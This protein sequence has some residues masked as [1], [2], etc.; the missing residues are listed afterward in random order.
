[1]RLDGLRSAF[2]GQLLDTLAGDREQTVSV[3]VLGRAPNGGL[4]VSAS[5]VELALALEPTYE[6]GSTIRVPQQLV[7][8]AQS[9]PRDVQAQALPARGETTSTITQTAKLLAEAIAATP[10]QAVRPTAPLATG[11]APAK[12]VAQ[13]LKNSVDVSGLFYESHVAEWAHGERPIAALAAEPQMQWARRADS[14][15]ATAPRTIVPVAGEAR[16]GA[17][18]LAVGTSATALAPE[19][20]HMIGQQAQVLDTGRVVWQGAVWPGQEARVTFEREP[21]V[22]DDRGPRD[23]DEQPRAAWRTTLAADLPQLGRV[24]AV[25]AFDGARVSVRLRAP[26]TGAVP[27]LAASQREFADALAAAGVAIDSITVT[28]DG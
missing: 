21:V 4:L 6:P 14:V 20:T 3:V 19:A 18:P 22:E 10:E 25:I 7:A 16:T 26:A 11:A 23:A 1:M 17:A 28:R 27:A 12:E 24:D 5:G 9:A 13:S 15:P 8:E 2:V